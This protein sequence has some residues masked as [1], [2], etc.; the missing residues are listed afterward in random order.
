[1]DAD[2]WVLPA[3]TF[4]ARING[5]CVCGAV[6]W[7][8][9]A[10]LSSMLYCHCSICRKHHGTWFAAFVAGPL[11]TFHWRA[12]TEKISTWKSSEHGQRSFCSVC[13][14]KVATVNNE[15]QQVFMPAG[16]L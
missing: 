5:A 1:M 6:R 10:A 15:L 7:S 12:G 4:S 14:S 11:G 3:E 8:Y 2:T 13:G 16:A 9:D